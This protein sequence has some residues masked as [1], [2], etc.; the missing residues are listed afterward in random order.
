M[1]CM[2]G[3]DWKGVVGKRKVKKTPTVNPVI[4]KVEMLFN[5]DIS[6]AG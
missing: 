4:Q 6:N 2:S 5:Y 1:C 3:R